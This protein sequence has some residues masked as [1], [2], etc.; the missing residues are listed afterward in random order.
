MSV[1]EID[2]NEVGLLLCCES[3]FPVIS[4]KFWPVVPLTVVWCSLPSSASDC[5]MV[6]LARHDLIQEALDNVLLI[7]WPTD[8]SSMVLS[9][10]YCED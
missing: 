3:L 6:Q 4:L 8:H 7:C 10:Y 2:T 1:I 9:I 5:D